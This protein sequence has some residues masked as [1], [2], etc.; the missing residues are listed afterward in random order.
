LSVYLIAE[1]KLL[2]MQPPASAHVV[3]ATAMR[4]FRSDAD[5]QIKGANAYTVLAEAGRTPN[6]LLDRI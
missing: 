3:I 2:L 4:T 5:M 1:N 6:P